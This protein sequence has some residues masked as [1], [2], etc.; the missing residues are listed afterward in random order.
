MAKRVVLCDTGILIEVFRKNE[1]I[2]N[3]LLELGEE[4]LAISVITTAEILYGM[5]KHEK[6]KTK[7]LLRRFK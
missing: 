7:A 3:T 4:N 1:E 2:K 6:K 5:R